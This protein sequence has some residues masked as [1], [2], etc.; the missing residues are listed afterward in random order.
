MQS[1]KT[2]LSASLF[3]FATF[4]AV[5]QS[6]TGSVTGSMAHARSGQGTAVLQN[7]NVL[8][9]GGFNIGG[10][11]RHRRNLQSGNHDVVGDG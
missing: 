10:Y 11:R 4:A 9:V 6:G 7:G 2:L 8:L 1:R 5:G 3:V